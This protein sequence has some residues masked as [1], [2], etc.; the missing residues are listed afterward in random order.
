MARIGVP[1][2]EPV[3]G[4]RVRAQAAPTRHNHRGSPGVETRSLRAGRK[5]FRLSV[6]G[7]TFNPVGRYQAW[8][9]LAVP[10]VNR[11]SPWRASARR[12]GS[13]GPFCE[14]RTST[15]CLRVSGWNPG[16]LWPGPLTVA[17]DGTNNQSNKVFGRSDG[18]PIDDEVDAEAEDRRHTASGKS[19]KKWVLSNPGIALWLVASEGRPP[20]RGL[21]HEAALAEG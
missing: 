15:R 17:N 18:S 1:P 14:A 21:G 9:C 10:A 8:H 12:L 13:L 3:T 4:L 19:M 11:A 20:S 7:R 16:H 6:E 2:L 5:P